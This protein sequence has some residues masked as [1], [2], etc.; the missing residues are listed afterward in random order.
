MH[1]V[2]GLVH[3]RDR[4]WIEKYFLGFFHVADPGW[5]EL[6]HMGKALKVL[7]GK[8]ACMQMTIIVNR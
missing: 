1:E 4:Q 6:R 7:G 8:R 5:R 3:R 2:E